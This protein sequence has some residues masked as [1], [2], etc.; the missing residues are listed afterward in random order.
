MIFF[1]LHQAV[2]S[3]QN[4]LMIER[5]KLFNET[6]EKMTAIVAVGGFP[7]KK[8]SSGSFTWCG[9]ECT[10]ELLKINILEA[11]GLSGVLTFMNPTHKSLLDLGKICQ[12]K[13]HNWALKWINVSIFFNGHERDVELAFARDTRFFLSWPSGS[14]RNYDN[15]NLPFVA[16]G[17]L[18]DWAKFCSN[19]NIT[20]KD[21]IKPV[22]AA[23]EDA[24]ALVDLFKE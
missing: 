14:T 3:V 17:S 9:S 8:N 20:G 1:D 11:W 22:V 19:E 4:T 5:C 18:S 12:E 23:M 13:N 15:I 24:K 2:S 10:V 6:F 7:I 21:F 16:T